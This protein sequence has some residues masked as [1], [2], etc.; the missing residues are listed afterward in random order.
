L[1]PWRL[2]LLRLWRTQRLIALAVAFGLVG[3]GIPILDHHLPEILKHAHGGGVRIIVPPPTPAQTLADVGN[4]ISQLGTLVLVMVAAASLA[5]DARPPLAT[6]YRTRA[7]DPKTL[8]L[9]RYAAVT[10]AGVLTLALGVL[11]AWYETAVLI[12]PP[13]VLALAGGFGLEAAW[14]CFAVATVAAWASFTPGVLAITGASLASLLSLA[15]L[16]NIPALST[17]SPAALAAS[18]G[19]LARIHH[20]TFPWHAIITAAATTVALLAVSASR[21]PRAAR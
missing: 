13:G 11:A 10:I 18:M 1:S 12:G 17:W 2:E 9:P 8:L 7:R 19:D 15:L 16:A 3:L 21:L 5:I 20:P 4:N 14:L 6:F